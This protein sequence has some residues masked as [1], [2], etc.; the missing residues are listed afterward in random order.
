MLDPTVMGQATTYSN[1]NL[2]A[3]KTEFLPGT[4]LFNRVELA[5]GN[6]AIQGDERPSRCIVA[7]ASRKDFRYLD[8]TNGIRDRPKLS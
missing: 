3:R 6:S 4:T 2:A 8:L 5:S 7:S 1:Q